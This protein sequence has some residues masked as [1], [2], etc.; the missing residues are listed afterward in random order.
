MSNLVFPARSGCC[1]RLAV[2]L[3]GARIRPRETPGDTRPGHDLDSDVTYVVSM[4]QW[5]GHSQNVI[6]STETLERARH[7]SRCAHA[8]MQVQYGVGTKG[9]T[10][11]VQP[12][13]G[14][15]QT[16]RPPVIVVVVVDRRREARRARSQVI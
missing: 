1:R 5:I 15:S 16:M 2:V 3:Y 9:T 12:P 6:G 4:M 7:A 8:H 14:R 13:R 11:A 10:H